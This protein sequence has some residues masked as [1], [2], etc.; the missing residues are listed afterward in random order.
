MNSARRIGWQ[1]FFD[2]VSGNVGDAE[3]AALEAVGQLFVIQTE[4]SQNRGMHVV[5]VDGIF[6]DSP[7]DFVRLAND[8]SALHAAARQPHAE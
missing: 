8:L 2:D 7:A 4:Q 1:Q 5:N 3:V 6:R